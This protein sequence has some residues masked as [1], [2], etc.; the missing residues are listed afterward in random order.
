MSGIGILA[1]GIAV[2]SGGLDLEFWAFERTKPSP[3]Y[4]GPPKIP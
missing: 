1:F 3:H 4:L 2:G